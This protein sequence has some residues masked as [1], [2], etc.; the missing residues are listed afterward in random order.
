MIFLLIS[1]NT[2]TIKMPVLPLG[3]AYAARAVEEETPSVA[4]ATA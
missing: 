4:N 1:A 3:M 2:N